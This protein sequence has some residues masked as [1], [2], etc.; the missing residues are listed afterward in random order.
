MIPVVPQPEPVAP[1]FDFRREV[2]ERGEDAIRQMAGLTLSRTWIGRPIGRRVERVQDLTV[3]MLRAH[4]YWTKAMPNLH[5]AYGGLCAYLARYVPLDAPPTTDHFVALRHGGDPMLAYT[6]SNYRLASWYANGCKTSSEGVLDPFEVGDGWFALDLNSFKTIVGPT[7][8]PERREQI[9]RTIDVLGLAKR[10]VAESRRRDAARYW[11][12][13]AG[14]RP[15]PLWSLE[16]DAPFLARELRR[17][18]RV[19]PEDLSPR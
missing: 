16:Q 15:I 4:P 2:Y 11:S 9:E 19:R 10:E 12:P 8:P 3:E 6:W 5:R 7:A 18:G 14:T 1:G 17:Q 13:P